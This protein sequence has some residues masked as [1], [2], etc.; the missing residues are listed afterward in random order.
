MSLL[1]LR[2]KVE[3]NYRSYT[4]PNHFILSSLDGQLSFHSESVFKNWLHQ[5]LLLKLGL[6]SKGF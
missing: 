3:I 5:V 4:P 1:W 2:L 6:R